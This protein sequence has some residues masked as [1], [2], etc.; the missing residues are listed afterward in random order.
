MKGTLVSP[1]V[2]S[3]PHFISGIIEQQIPIM[4]CYLWRLTCRMWWKIWKETGNKEMKWWILEVIIDDLHLAGQD[5]IHY[6]APRRN[7]I[8][9]ECFMD[10]FSCRILLSCTPHEE[11][12][13]SAEMQ[14]H[15]LNESISQL[16]G[17]MYTC[18][19]S[20]TVSWDC[21]PSIYQLMTDGDSLKT[22]PTE[23]TDRFQ[24]RWVLQR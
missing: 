18:A 5:R 9:R 22:S 3:I 21:L 4:V 10:G 16:T 1:D 20:I 12:W 24:H 8:Y 2:I 23:K 15:P 7:L 14:L 17:K 6:M 13:R 19:N 11:N